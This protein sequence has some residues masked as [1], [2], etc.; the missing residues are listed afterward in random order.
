MRIGLKLV[1]SLSYVNLLR[2]ASP[3]LAPLEGTWTRVGVI[4]SHQVSLEHMRMWLQPLINEHMKC[5]CMYSHLHTGEH[6]IMGLPLSLALA[7]TLWEKLHAWMCFIC[8]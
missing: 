4:W 2:F 5:A 6:V 7:L 3:S 1:F 8:L